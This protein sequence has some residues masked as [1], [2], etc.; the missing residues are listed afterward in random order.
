MTDRPQV[1]ESITNHKEAPLITE[2]LVITLNSIHILIGLVWV[3]FEHI[4]ISFHPQMCAF[5]AYG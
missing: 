1:Y 5:C 2:Q 3:S 4:C